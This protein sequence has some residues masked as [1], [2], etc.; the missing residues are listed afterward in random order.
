MTHAIFLE[1]GGDH[2]NLLLATSEI[3]IWEIDA[4][5]GDAVRNLRHDQLFGHDQLLDRWSVEIFLSYVFEE[6]RE[7]VSGLLQSSL[8]DGMPWAIETRIRRADGVD[9]WISAKG[10]PKFSD[11]GEVE[12]LIGHV[13]D[14]TATK[15][16]EDRLRLLSKELNHR[17]ANTF[18]IMNSMI[19]HASKKT[20]TVN[21]FA[22]TLMDRLA[23]LA[24]SNKVLVANEAERSS[25]HY[26]L[27]MELEAFQGWQKRISVAGNTHVW[28]SGEA[29]EALALI[30]HELLTN[31]VKHGALSVPTGRV[32]VTVTQGGNRQVDIHWT[33]T[34]GPS[35]AGERRR[36][37]GS[38]ILQN[39]M[40]DQGRVSLDFAPQGLICDIAINDSYLR[41]NPD[42]SAPVTPVGPDPQNIDDGA[43]SGQRILVV[44]DDPIIGLDI[45]DILTSRGARVIGPFTNV[46]S[47]LKAIRDKPDAALLD[48]NLGQETTDPVALQL[49]ELSIPFLVLSGQLDSSDLGEAF[50]GVSIMAKPFRERDLV[51]ALYRLF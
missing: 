13:I 35:L 9:R 8:E 4:A 32:N 24:R 10:M 12:K 45:S 36:G 6:D 41:E 25:L 15:Q 31:A 42:S 39:A 47:A 33:E 5:T 40:R 28:F 22:Q 7:R 29:S 20:S 23:A 11:T 50:R 26:I 27:Q 21:Q 2:L 3:G 14:I 34:G 51:S 18:T 19:R 46:A 38:T 30:F 17:V 49:S 44:E 16:S 1:N 43:F 37:I 48:V